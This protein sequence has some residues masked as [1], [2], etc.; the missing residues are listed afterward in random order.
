M[1]LFVVF[2][3]DTCSVYSVHTF[4]PTEGTSEIK[5]QWDVAAS[6]S[7]GS[8]CG[9]GDCHGMSSNPPL[10]DSFPS[11]MWQFAAEAVS[12]FLSLRGEEGHKDFWAGES[13]F[14]LAFVLQVCKLNT[15]F[16]L[17]FFKIQ[18]SDNWKLRGTYQLRMVLA[19]SLSPNSNLGQISKK[20]Q[21]QPVYF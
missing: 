2:L 8:R 16:F 19:S 12:S 10:L 13:S 1:K 17:S 11:G 6:E 3:K 5:R 21:N 18:N 4:S 15:S 9:C 7:L 20:N 14:L